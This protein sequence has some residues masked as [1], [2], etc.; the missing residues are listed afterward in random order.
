MTPNLKRV[1]T[2]LS[3]FLLLPLLKLVGVISG[4][5]LYAWAPLLAAVGGLAAVAL[6][7][8]LLTLFYSN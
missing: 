1:L 2:F 3:V 8:L 4:P 6:V 7:V 5:W